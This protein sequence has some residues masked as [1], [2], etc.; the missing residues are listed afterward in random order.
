MAQY[1]YKCNNPKCQVEFDVEHPI[2]QP[3]GAECPVC[4]SLS[5]TRLVSQTSFVLK[6]PRWYRDGY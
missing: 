5:P 4:G 1:T 3:A 6:G 2:S